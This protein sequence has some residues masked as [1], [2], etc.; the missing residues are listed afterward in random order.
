MFYA[1]K[2][3]FHG[4]NKPVFIEGH[5][6]DTSLPFVCPLFSQRSSMVYDVVYI[7]VGHL[8]NGVMPCTGSNFGILLQDGAYTFK[9]T[10]RAV[11]NGIGHFIIG[12]APTT[13]RPHEVIFVVADKH[14][15]PFDIIFW[16]DLLIDVAILER[17]Q[18]FEVV[19]KLYHITVTPPAVEH[20]VLPVL[21]FKHKLVDGLCPVYNLI[22]KRLAKQILIGTFRF[23][24]NRHTDAAYFSLVNVVRS[25][26]QVIFTVF[27]DNAGSPHRL[28]SPF[29]FSCIDNTCMLCPFG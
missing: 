14:E 2:R 20:V 11:C 26:K 24:G 1:F 3:H 16:R 9:R 27:L 18:A 15:W 25:E 22:N 12:P 23:V 7:F 6:V 8:D 28:F 10:E 29:Y 17:D 21:I 13:F 5:A 19:A 4:V